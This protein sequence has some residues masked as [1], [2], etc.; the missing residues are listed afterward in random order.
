MVG[1]CIVCTLESRERK[2][3]A[4][5]TIVRVAVELQNFQVA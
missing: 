2:Q 4:S 1:M 3:I 5:K